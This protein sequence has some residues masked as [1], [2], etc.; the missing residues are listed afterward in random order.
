MMEKSFIVDWEMFE[1]DSGKSIKKG[2]QE[3][4]RSR[5]RTI[6]GPGI[7]GSTLD[8]LRKGETVVFESKAMNQ[9]AVYTPRKKEA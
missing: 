8:R 1:L 4:E 3:C 2:S 5:M 9:R 6:V 7:N